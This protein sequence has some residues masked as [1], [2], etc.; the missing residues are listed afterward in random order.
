MSMINACT[1]VHG[2][3][4]NTDNCHMDFDKL[5]NN[6]NNNGNYHQKN[7]ETLNANH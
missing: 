4:K 3:V 5:H 2:T 7:H 1:A 6:N